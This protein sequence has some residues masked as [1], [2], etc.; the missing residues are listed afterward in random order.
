MPLR[1]ASVC[2]V[3]ALPFDHAYFSSKLCGSALCRN[4]LGVPFPNNF[5]GPF[6]GISGITDVAVVRRALHVIITGSGGGT[7][8]NTYTKK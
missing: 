2:V 5:T 6:L 1:V 8:K 3:Q 4:R 7:K